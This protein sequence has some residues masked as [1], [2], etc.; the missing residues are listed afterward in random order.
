MRR[1]GLTAAVCGMAAC[2][3]GDEGGSA[4]RVAGSGAAFCQEVMPRVEAYLEQARREHPTP[5]DERYGGTVVVASIG[6]LPEGMMSAQMA[7]YAAQ[8]H[9]Q[10]VNLMTLIDYDENARARP[11]LAESFEVAEDGSSV[12]FHL[13]RD[14]FWHDGEPT[15]AHDVAF[16]YEVVTDPVT[17]YP[18]ISFWDRYVKGPEGVEVVDDYT[19]T[20]RMEPHSEFLDSF[21]ALGILPEH[22]LA[23]VPRDQLGQHP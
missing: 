9:Q 19:I 16:T 2:G 14:V 17:A 21:R 13:R 20:I 12:T 18:N 1:V 6:D 5:D 15:D 23:D 10:F 11:Y 8:Q 7:D 22:L 4:A 3:G